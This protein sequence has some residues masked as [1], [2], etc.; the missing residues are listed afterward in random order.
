MA[1]AAG[2]VEETTGDNATTVDNT[3]SGDMGDDVV[4]DEPDFADPLTVVVS[5]HGVRK[6]IDFDVFMTD[7]KAQF[8]QAMERLVGCRHSHELRNIELLLGAAADFDAVMDRGTVNSH[9]L[10]FTF[11]ADVPGLLTVS[12]LDAP[13][14]FPQ[15]RIREYM[16][17]F[18]TVT[19]DFKVHAPRAGKKVFTGNRCF[20]MVMSDDN[21]VPYRFTICGRKMRAIYDGVQPTAPGPNVWARRAAERQ[22]HQQQHPP[23][24]PRVKQ[25]PQPSQQTGQP[26]QQQNQQRQQPQQ[27]SQRPPQQQPSKQPSQSSP[28]DSRS[29]PAGSSH[30][31]QQQQRRSRS[32]EDRRDLPPQQ[33]Q[34]ETAGG[35]RGGRGRGHHL[36]GYGPRGRPRASSGPA[37]PECLPNKFTISGFEDLTDPSD[38]PLPVG[39][40][41]QPSKASR[42]KAAKPISSS[43]PASPVDDR[44]YPKPKPA[45]K[46]GTKATRKQQAEAGGASTS[47]PE[48]AAAGNPF[49]DMTDG[50]YVVTNEGVRIDPLDP[51]SSKDLHGIQTRWI[52]LKRKGTLTLSQRLGSCTLGRDKNIPPETVW[53][54]Q[55]GMVNG[56]YVETGTKRLDVYDMFAGG[57]SFLREVVDRMQQKPGDDVLCALHNFLHYGP[58]HKLKRVPRKTSYEAQ[59]WWEKWGSDVDT[60]KG[61]FSEHIGDLAVSLARYSGG[62]SDAP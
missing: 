15:E 10:A 56:R 33:E 12:V 54:E 55:G 21:P 61:H 3:N 32:K 43:T 5:T 14:A 29:T 44:Q 31:A 20:R 37:Q 36:G 27:P 50:E 9:G 40:D 19:H 42:K 1:A 17:Q 2:D 7:F 25:P 11:E 45:A 38:F 16:M 52:L 58:I 53:T 62:D 30:V 47:T 41:K 46:E 35:T 59:E 60:V 6:V 57:E 34:W 39:A 48:P 51:E 13:L 24:Q 4:E 49:R 22:Q 28:H 23:P 18:G 8:P 26:Q